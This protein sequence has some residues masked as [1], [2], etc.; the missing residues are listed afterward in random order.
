[1]LAVAIL[2]TLAVGVFGAALDQRLAGL[3]VPGD[4]RRALLLE[5]PKLAE[6]R[7]PE[8]AGAEMRATLARAL[9]ESFV[10]SFRVMMLVAAALAVLS[11]VCAALTIGPSRRRPAR[12]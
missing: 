5:V 12:S 2:G 9:T 11:A 3:A 10:S 1:M 4:V 7:V 8:A 6:A